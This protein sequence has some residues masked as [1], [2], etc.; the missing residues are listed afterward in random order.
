MLEEQ[1]N[2]TVDEDKLNSI[3]D[4]VESDSDASNK[5]EQLKNIIEEN[6][7]DSSTEIKKEVISTQSTELHVE[8][9]ESEDP[10]KTELDEILNEP[11][12]EDDDDIKVEEVKV[13]AIEQ[14]AV[15]EK[16]PDPL[17]IVEEYEN[18]VLTTVELKTQ[19]NTK[20][21]PSDFRPIRRMTYQVYKKIGEKLLG[22][23]DATRFAGRH[24]C[25][26]VI[27]IINN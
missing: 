1:K 21:K 9:R 4:D 23:V 2:D 16:E 8:V 6:D 25:I 13:S 24:T 7:S 27:F 14:K 26:K 22:S 5:D 20:T 12:D 3:L 18:S 19:L 15:K 17:E 11:D 10:Y